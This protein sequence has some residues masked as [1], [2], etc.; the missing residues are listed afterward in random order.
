M[1]SRKSGSCWGPSRL[2]PDRITS[3]PGKQSSDGNQALDGSRSNASIAPSIIPPLKSIVAPLKY[4][5]LGPA[6]RLTTLH[7]SYTVHI[8]RAGIKRSCA[9]VI[10]SSLSFP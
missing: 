9:R 7:T 1:S 3:R 5:S 2:R 6:R 4:S 8:R 10:A